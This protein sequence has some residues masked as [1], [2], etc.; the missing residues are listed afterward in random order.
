MP[1]QTTHFWVGKFENQSLFDQFFEE[2]YSEND[3]D[4]ISKFAESQDET[5]IDHDFLEMGFENLNLPLR[6]KF[7]N[8]S[9]A[10]RWIAEFE[11]KVQEKGIS[12]I[13]TILMC[14]EDKDNIQI[15]SPKSF[16]GDG[17]RLEYL[18]KIN[19]DYEHP[20]W[21]KDILNG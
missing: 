17:Y 9:Y 21:F 11:K 1:N 7:A 13:N 10:D 15:N 12:E 6:E 3:E 14:N 18:G 16:S 20:Q 19:F 2:S 8:Y 5:W 4:S